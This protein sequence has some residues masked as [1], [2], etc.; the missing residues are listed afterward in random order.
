MFVWNKD[1]INN[2][3]VSPNTDLLPE[4]Q[5][6]AL[7][8]RCALI[9]P[10][11]QMLFN[12][13]STH[14]RQKVLNVLIYIYCGAQWIDEFLPN[15]NGTENQIWIKLILFFLVSLSSAKNKSSES[16]SAHELG[17]RSFVTSVTWSFPR[18]LSTLEKS[19]QHNCGKFSLY[20]S[21]KKSRRIS[22][23]FWEDSSKIVF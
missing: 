16:P 6:F 3:Y 20:L 18:V 19:A 11:Q 13:A 2:F 22:E 9:F 7:T 1:W 17:V 5:G 14:S 4:P 12:V 21:R 10:V 8:R 15:W 23:G